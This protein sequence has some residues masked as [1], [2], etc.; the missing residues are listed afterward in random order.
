[1]SQTDA[2]APAPAYADLVL[3]GGGVKGIGHAGAIS[4]LAAAG[5]TFPR[6]AGTSAGAIVGAIVAAMQA[7]GEP[8]DRLADV[9]RS[10]DYTEFRDPS[11]LG[12]IAGPV[13]DGVNFLLDDGLYEGDY[14]L[15]WLRGALGAL[16]VTTFA[17]LALPADPEG[18][19]PAGH[20]Y[21]L[22]VTASDLSRRRLALL[23]WDCPGYGLDPDEQ[24]VAEA[25]RASASIPYFFEPVRLRTGDG[26]QVTLVDGGLL[27]NYP[28]AAFDR[29]DGLLPRWPTFGI[30]L[31]AR[32]SVRPVTHEVGGPLS[33]TGAVVETLLTAQDAVHVDDACDAGRTIFVDTTGVS[34]TDF[35]ISDAEQSQ[36]FGNGAQAAVRFLDRWIFPAYVEACRGGPQ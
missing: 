35:D 21:R 3:E 26:E 7:Y 13:G 8:L 36:L 23:P 6:V 34:A 2:A 15:E 28:I 19:L 20:R 31:S 17:D 4:V 18:D 5:Y 22:L 33:L 29:T 9:V 27:S 11:L 32:P 30:R 10:I 14:L 12:R 16:G 24:P 1:V 25:V